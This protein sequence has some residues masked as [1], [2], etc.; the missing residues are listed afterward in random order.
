[1]KT[2]LIYRPNSEHERQALDYLHDFTAQTG[3]TLSTL[4][5]DSPEGVDICRLYDIMQFPALLATDNEGHVQNI[6]LAG[7][8]P[9]FSEASYYVEETT[10]RNDRT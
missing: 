10:A 6:W 3:K 2:V 8:L 4:N 5:P 7:N 1:M 9:T